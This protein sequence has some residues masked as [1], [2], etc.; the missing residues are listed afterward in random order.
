MYDCFLCRVVLVRN[1]LHG[2]KYNNQLRDLVHL[3][4]IHHQHRNLSI[5][6]MI[7]TTKLT[8]LALLGVTRLAHA[9]SIQSAKSVKRDTC[10]QNVMVT[11]SIVSDS[12]LLNKVA[13]Y[14]CSNLHGQFT[15]QLSP[16][17]NYLFFIQ[18]EAQASCVQP[19]APCHANCDVNL[20][21]NTGNTLTLVAN[22]Q[23][24]CHCNNG[25]FVEDLL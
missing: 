4:S 3:N 1:L 13:S 12:P 17:A 25:T 19:V 10:P 16:A 11:T 6:R 21:A 20:L 9:R 15:D 14:T 8:L 5:D 24:E 23:V 2:R 22:A 18:G 7:M